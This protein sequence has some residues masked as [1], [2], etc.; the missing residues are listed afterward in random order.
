MRP[1][2]DDIAGRNRERRQH[3]KRNQ[4]AP[5][6]VIALKS[7]LRIGNVRIVVER[8]LRLSAC[9]LVRSSQGAIHHECYVGA[10][11]DGIVR[12]NFDRNCHNTAEDVEA[13]NDLEAH[14]RI[15]FRDGQYY[16]E[17]REKKR[18]K[19]AEIQIWERVYG[20]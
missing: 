1:G 19:D 5:R 6:A 11:Q 3:E 4:I 7:P 15:E 9:C 16:N 18:A 14:G 20:R 12:A 8:L 13:M 10:T 17:A 2:I